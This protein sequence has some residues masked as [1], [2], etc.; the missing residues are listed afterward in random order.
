MPVNPAEARA[1]ARRRRRDRLLLLPALQGGVRAS[2]AI[3]WFSGAAGHVLR[4]VDAADECPRRRK[5]AGR[6]GLRLAAV[7]PGIEPIPCRQTRTLSPKFVRHRCWNAVRMRAFLG[8]CAGEARLAT[9]AGAA[10]HSR[11]PPRRCARHYWGRNLRTTLR[12]KGA[13]EFAGDSWPDQRAVRSHAHELLV[14]PLIAE[15]L[16]LRSEA[17]PNQLVAL[18]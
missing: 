3:R 13:E 12:R 1:H 8:T 11:L 15:R 14:V 18:A 7:A 2:S 9:A 5:A 6:P 16:K 10:G 17:R 4:Q